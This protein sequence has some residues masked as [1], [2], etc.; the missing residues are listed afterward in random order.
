[1]V[2]SR[3]QDY[4]SG[5]QNSDRFHPDGRRSY[6]TATFA[7]PAADA[8]FPVYR[9]SGTPTYL[10]GFL[11]ATLTAGKA[12]AGGEAAGCRGG[13]TQSGLFPLQGRGQ[14]PGRAGATAE[15]TEA[16]SPAAEIHDR[17]FDIGWEGDDLF[18]AGVPA[19][20]AFATLPDPFEDT[21][22]WAD[23][24]SPFIPTFRAT[25]GDE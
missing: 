3:A 6:G 24:L 10:D 1:M 11:G 5:L 22:R 14:D 8:A 20:I 17:A 19:E 2:R 15:I 25:G 18:R 12:T 13:Q 21:P 23:K 7:A 4:R 16:A 9:D